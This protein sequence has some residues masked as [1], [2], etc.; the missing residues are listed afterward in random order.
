MPSHARVRHLVRMRPPGG[1]EAVP[2]SSI[3]ALGT[4]VGAD[5]RSPKWTSG[6][7]LEIDVFTPSRPDF[8]LF[9]ALVEPLGDVE[10]A[11][12]L[13]APQPYLTEDQVFE[14]AR[15]YFNSERYW[16][17]HEVLEVAWRAMSGME[18]AYVQGIIL[19]CAAFVHHQKGEDAVA[20]GVM[21]RALGSIGIM[22]TTFRGIDSDLL[23]TNVELIL[24]SGDFRPF[25]I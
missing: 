24:Q 25:T 7:S 8:D 5:V 4:S 10:F 12:D 6:G 14:E 9:L 19:V 20:L 11:R 17:C 1:S 22:K 21:R 15:R 16:E 13:G 18:K 23:R 3:R 2:L